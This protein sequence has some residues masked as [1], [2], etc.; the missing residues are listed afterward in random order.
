M[1]AQFVH[2]HAGAEQVAVAVNVVDTVH[3]SARTCCRL[4]M[5]SWEVTASRRCCRDDPSLPRTVGLG[6]RGVL[7]RVVVGRNLGTSSMA[8]LVRGCLQHGGNEAVQLALGLP[9]SVGS[10]MMRP[11][12]R[13]AHGR[14]V[15]AVIHQPLGNIH[16]GDAG[17]SALMGPNDRGCT[18]GR[19]DPG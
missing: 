5:R 1:S 8:D 10:T 19:R 17:G 6:V 7:E 18:R 13:E 11:R 2:R 12:H 9:I 16:L 4:P 15:E 14:G 3:R